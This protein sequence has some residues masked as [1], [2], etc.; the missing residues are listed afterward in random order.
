MPA[1]RSTAA[2]L[3]ERYAK[4]LYALASEQKTVP[5]LAKDSADFQALVA[6]HAGLARL[7]RDPSLNADDQA[8]A[9][10]AITKP[11][12]PLLGKLAAVMARRNRLSILPEVL[13]A[14]QR[15]VREADGETDVTVT[16]AH[17]LKAPQK[18][19]IEA[20]VVK[21]AGKKAHITY[22][23]DASL[24]GGFQIHMGSVLVDATSKQWLARLEQRLLSAVAA[25]A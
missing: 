14:F 20:M 15:M 17:P 7:L 13:A 23:E 8:R 11:A 6:S 19:Q 9:I 24:L 16:S 5:A 10:A 1:S 25:S 3:A 2:R 4:A 18:K 22:R 21:A 12:S